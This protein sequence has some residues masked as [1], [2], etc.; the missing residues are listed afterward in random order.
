MKERKGDRKLQ[1][2]KDQEGGEGGCAFLCLRVCY[3]ESVSGQD[4]RRIG[5]A[6]G[7][8]VLLVSEN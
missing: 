2:G 4:E 6:E 8:K 1:R 7:G 5:K 3:G